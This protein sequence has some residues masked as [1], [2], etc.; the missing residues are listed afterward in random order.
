MLNGA[1]GYRICSYSVYGRL[2]TLL[3]WTDFTLSAACIT[4]IEGVMENHA[5]YEDWTAPVSV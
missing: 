5:I 3:R 2:L 1:P 4:T